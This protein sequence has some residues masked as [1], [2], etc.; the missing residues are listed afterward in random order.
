MMALLASPSDFQVIALSATST[1]ISVSKL[2]LLCSMEVADCCAKQ[3]S[4]LSIFFPQPQ[5][6]PLPTYQPFASV[7]GFDKCCPVVACGTHR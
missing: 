3:A 1:L 4:R 2:T 7:G 5:G 6:F